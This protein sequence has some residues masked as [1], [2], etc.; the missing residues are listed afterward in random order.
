MNKVQCWECVKLLR[1]VPDVKELW[2]LYTCSPTPPVKGF[3]SFWLS[4]NLSK[5]GVRLDNHFD[6]SLQDLSF[7]YVSHWRDV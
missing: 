2:T 1:E 7:P 4:P 6:A 5:V 3:S